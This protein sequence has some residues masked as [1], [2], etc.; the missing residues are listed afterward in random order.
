LGALRDA[1]LVESDS[2]A[3]HDE[4][5]WHFTKPTPLCPMFETKQ[6]KPLDKPFISLVSF[7]YKDHQW[8]FHV[9]VRKTKAE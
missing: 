4:L 8:R 1:W 5:V 6:N 2:P 9:T 7:Y 3:R